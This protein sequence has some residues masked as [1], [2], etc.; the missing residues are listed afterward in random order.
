MSAAST[1]PVRRA[2][3]AAALGVALFVAACF[4]PRIGLYTGDAPADVKLFQTFGERFLAGEIPYRDY[5]VEY[6][7]GALPAFVLPALGES[8][9][10][11]LL[12]KLLHIAFGAAA[13]AL[14][15]LT[16]TL[17]GATRQRRY[18]TTA[19]LALAPLA[20]GP[21]VLNR[22]DLWPAV[23]LA[24]ALAGLVG[25]R[26][27]LGLALLAVAILAKGYALAVLPVALLYVFARHGRP[28]LRRGSIAFAATAF[29]VVAPFA[30]L[31]PGGLRHS[32]SIQTS[33]GLHL[34]SLGG[35]LLAAAD[36]V[37][38]YTAEVV[39]GFAFE[40]DGT[41][42][43]VVATLATLLQLAALVAAWVL[44][45]RGPATP[46]R[47]VVAAAASVAAFAAFAKVLSPQFLI[48]LLP[49]VP[50]A[51]GI[52]APALLLVALG[53]TQAFFPSR[54]RGVLD[55]EGETWLVVARNLVLVALF[56]A[57]AWRL[58][59]Q[60]EYTTNPPTAIRS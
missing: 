1:N 55:L 9:S 33:R 8:G 38:I 19:F 24:G 29:L 14:G 2:A 12:F 59:A 46:Q 47:L 23:L 16:L 42:P 10:Y 5:F 53:L 37:G 30:V 57:L 60:P 32:F 6:P 39:G 44:F 52:A 48:W 51:G 3:P 26:V 22:Y 45:K 36:R 18:L 34:E 43:D 13:I 15:A 21:T 58:R 27:A 49:L 41:L 31:G 7:P 40:L 4:A 17:L 50:L 25:G 35:S 20:L 11:V 56:A 28:G 54:Y